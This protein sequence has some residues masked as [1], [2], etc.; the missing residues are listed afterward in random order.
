MERS[1]PFPLFL[2]RLVDE[3]GKRIAAPEGIALE[4]P[5]EGIG[6]PRG[7]ERRREAEREDPGLLREVDG[8]VLPVLEEGKL[9]E[10]DVRKGE[11]RLFVPV[12]I[13]AEALDEGKVIEGKLVPSHF[14]RRP[15]ELGEGMGQGI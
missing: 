15:L 1:P 9:V 13:G 7:E 14:H 5:G 4:S 8:E 2:L 10:V 6:F 3:E 11:A 12:A